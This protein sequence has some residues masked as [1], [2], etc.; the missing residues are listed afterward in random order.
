M[1]KLVWIFVSLAWLAGATWWWHADEIEQ[2]IYDNQVAARACWKHYDEAQPGPGFHE[3]AEGNVERCYG[4]LARDLKERLAGVT[5]SNAAAVGIVPV[6]AAWT[7][8]LLVMRRR[9]A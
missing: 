6:V 8:G 9:A 2:I 4:A 3:L 7:I 1:N 5:W